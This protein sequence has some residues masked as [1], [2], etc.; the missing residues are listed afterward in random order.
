MFRLKVQACVLT[1]TALGLVMPV[2]AAREANPSGQDAPTAASA[3]QGVRLAQA[4]PDGPALSVSKAPVQSRKRFCCS[5]S[6]WSCCP[7]K[8]KA[9]MKK[10]SS[11]KTK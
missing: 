1:L 4:G 2:V 5:A 11:G 10:K 7:P 8:V 3:F 9:Q 6:N